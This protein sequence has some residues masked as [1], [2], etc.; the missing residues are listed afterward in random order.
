MK[1]EIYKTKFESGEKSVYIYRI[2]ANNGNGVVTIMP[3]STKRGKP[4]VGVRRAQLTTNIH[5]DDLIRASK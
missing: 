1:M 2:I 5:V 4:V 3:V